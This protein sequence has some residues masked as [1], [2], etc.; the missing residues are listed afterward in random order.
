MEKLKKPSKQR[1]YEMHKTKFKRI[2]RSLID[3]KKCRLIITENCDHFSATNNWSH[4]PATVDDAP[5]KLSQSESSLKK[6]LTAISL[7]SSFGFM[8]EFMRYASINW[9]EFAILTASWISD[10][11][12]LWIQLRLIWYDPIRSRF[13]LESARG[14]WRRKIESGRV[15]C[16][17]KSANLAGVRIVEV[18]KMQLPWKKQLGCGRLHNGRTLRESDANDVDYEGGWV[19]FKSDGL[20]KWFERKNLKSKKILCECGE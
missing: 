6:A 3:Q 20:L 9:L 19:K 10:C 7:V 11:F 4:L 17:L 15:L 8:N 5:V 2:S 16:V 12:A 13:E 14:G 18:A 1:N